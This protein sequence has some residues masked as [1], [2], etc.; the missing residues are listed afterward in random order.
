L[1]KSAN[2]TKDSLKNDIKRVVKS[3]YL[4]GKLIVKN[5]V[6]DIRIKAEFE[7]RTVAMSVKITPPQDKGTVA[8]IGWVNK[9]MENCKKK[10]PEL[11]TQLE[12]NIWIEADVKYAKENLKVKLNELAELTEESKGKEIQAF[13][14]VL[15]KGFGA[16]FASNKKFI[17]LME[18]MILDYYAAIVQQ[19]SSWNRPAPKLN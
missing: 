10:H 5:A 1:V 7:R 13:H 15:I 12:D 17:E 2:K 16:N 3:N 9:Q 11:F 14:V 4:K 18:N 6:S 19:M 8:R